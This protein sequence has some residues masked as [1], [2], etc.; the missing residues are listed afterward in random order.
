MGNKFL[1]ID[2][3]G[4]L[5]NNGSH[6]YFIYSGIYV[7][8]SKNVGNL[9]RRVNGLAKKNYIKGE[10]KGSTLGGRHR[11]KLIE[12]L[13]EQEGVKQYFIIGRNDY[14]DK[15]NFNNP[16]SVRKHKNYMLRRLIELIVSEKELNDNDTLNIKIDNESLNTGQYFQELDSY[17]NSYWKKNVS[18]IKHLEYGEF[19]PQCEA[20]FKLNYVDSKTD[21]IVQL[22]DIIANSKYKRFCDKKG[23]H[24]DL[25][26]ASGCIKHPRT[27]YSSKHSVD[28]YK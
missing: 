26:K 14:L 28:F 9:I 2:D 4:Q 19:I 22:A 3:S 20:E 21:R 25:L 15:V 1:Y 17:I 5:S 18:Y 24:S 8:N 6:D 10:F 13:R 23:C 7:N 16:Q 27:F 12:I 11:R